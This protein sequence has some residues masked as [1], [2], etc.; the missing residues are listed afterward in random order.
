MSRMNPGRAVART[1]ALPLP[2]ATALALALTLALPAFAQDVADG[3]R[4]TPVL[5]AADSLHP[6]TESSRNLPPQVTPVRSG[7]RKS[8]V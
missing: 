3:R 8:V 1:H 6:A 7:D 5:G 4:F 2:R